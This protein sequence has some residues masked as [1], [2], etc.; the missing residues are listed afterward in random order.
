MTLEE[1]RA[2]AKTLYTGEQ[3]A[4]TLAFLFG[5]A[6]LLWRRMGGPDFTFP[7]AWAAVSLG[8]ALFAYVFVRRVRFVRAEPSDPKA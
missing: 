5:V 7:L 3:I 4:G 6:M 8:W 1:R 2:H